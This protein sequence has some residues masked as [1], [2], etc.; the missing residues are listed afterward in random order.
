M[1]PPSYFAAIFPCCSVFKKLE[2]EIVAVKIMTILKRTG[3]TFRDLS[4]EEYQNERLKDG[5]FSEIENQI[6]NTVI[7]YCKNET[8]AQNFSEEWQIKINKF[9]FI[10]MQS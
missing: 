10:E 9:D 2:Y 8:V 7:R 4:F 3:D 1:K 6:F 5:D